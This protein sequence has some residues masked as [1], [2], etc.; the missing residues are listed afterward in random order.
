VKSLDGKTIEEFAAAYAE[1]WQLGS[2]ER[3]DGLIIA[4]APNDHETV[5]MPTVHMTA[6]YPREWCAEVLQ[7]ALLPQFGKKDFA[8][9]LTKAVDMIV[10][11]MAQ[12]PTLPAKSGGGG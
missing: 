4:V 5:V 12:Y 8:G 11:R 2:Q 6:N 3:D 1:Q 9:G 10:A 7:K